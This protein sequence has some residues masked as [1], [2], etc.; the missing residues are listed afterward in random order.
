MVNNNQFKMINTFFSVSF[1]P[2]NPDVVYQVIYYIKIYLLFHSTF[3]WGIYLRKYLL[4]FL[5]SSL[6][7]EGWSSS[8][9]RW[10]H[11]S[12]FVAIRNE[13]K[14]HES[15]IFK[16][17]CPILLAMKLSPQF[18]LG[19]FAQLHEQFKQLPTY[20]SLMFV[21]VSSDVSFGIFGKFSSISWTFYNTI[22]YVLLLISKS[23]WLYDR[24]T[25]SVD[26]T[27]FPEIV[28]CMRVRQNTLNQTS[29]MQ[30]LKHQD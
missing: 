13:K 11:M 9:I 26:S 12:T 27:A 25:F 10:K 19:K 28:A 24:F 3:V 2:S 17:R 29:L 18:H 5:L 1:H 8:D 4:L 20:N 7:F 14:L 22:H 16:L 30:P 15:W 21:F 6:M 23:T